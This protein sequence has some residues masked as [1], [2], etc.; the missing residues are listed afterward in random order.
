MKVLTRGL[1]YSDLVYTDEAV[2]QRR[3]DKPG[4]VACMSREISRI[5]VCGGLRLH[6]EGLVREIG[7]ADLCDVRQRVFAPM[8]V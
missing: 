2:T 8:F 7:S 6:W 3:W 5:V 4:L 1:V